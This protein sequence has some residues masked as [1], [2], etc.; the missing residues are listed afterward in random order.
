M[1]REIC[2]I[3]S[4]AAL[5]LA[6]G[7]GWLAAQATDGSITGRIVDRV[8][9]APIAAAQVTVVGTNRGTS[10]GDDGRFRILGLKPGEVLVRALRIG[11][12]AEARRAVVIPG[13]AAT[14]DFNLGTATVSLDEV[15]VTA[16]GEQERK[17]ETGNVISTIQPV[18]EVLAATTNA[19][20]LLQGRAPG[21]DVNISGGTTGGG[22]RIRI[23]GASSI[24]LSNEPLLIIDG[25][26]TNND[27][28][29]TTIGVGG[30]APSRLN[31]LNPEDIESIEVLKGPAASALFGTAAANGVIQVRTKRGRAGKT[32]W[33][34]F[35]EGGSIEKI[36]NYPANYA[37]PGVRVVGGAAT[38][39][40]TLD[41]QTRNICTPTGGI[42][43]FSPLEAASPFV[44]GYREAYGIS[45]AG[46]SENVNYYISGDYD[47]EQGVIAWNNDQRVNMRANLNAQLRNNL[48]VSVGIGYLADH[49][50]SPQN[51][52]NVLGV[53]SGG[54]LGSAFDDINTGCGATCARGYLSGQTPGQVSAINTRQDINRF[55]NSVNANYQPLRWL[56]LNG[57]AGLD[58]NN[59]LDTEVI[60]PNTVFFGS[61]PDG[62]ATSNPYNIFDYTANGNASASFDLTSTLR[63]TTSGG[64][65]FNKEVVKGTRAHGELLL[66]GTN[67]LS[68]ASARFT[69]NAANTD[70]KT[71]GFYGQEQIAWRDRLFITGAVREDNNSAFGKSFGFIKYPAV[72]GSYVVSE[73]SY[74]PRVPTLSSLRL[75]AAY[76][77]S[78]QRPNFRDAITYFQ[79]QTVTVGTTDAP[80]VLI[81]GLGDPKLK[82]ER[83][84]ET[85]LG[86][87][88][89]FFSNRVSIE[90]THYY[91]KTKDLLVAVPVAPS[92]G[93]ATSKFSNLGS[94]ENK[95]WELSLNAS[96]LNRKKVEAS[97][98][99]SGSTNTNNL[100]FLGLLPTGK[101][102]P[103]I[104]F[105]N[106]SGLSQQHRAN[107]PLGGYWARPYTYSDANL[108]GIIS[109][110]E[111]VVSD[112]S[113]YYGN[114]IPT[115]EIAFLPRIKLFNLVTVSALLEYK[116]GFKQF[117]L[118]RRF[119]CNF[120]NCQESV[121]KTRP[122]ADQAANIGQLLGT[123]AGFIENSQYT[124]LRELAFSITAPNRVARFLRA[125][126]ASITVAGRNLKTWTKYTGFDPEVNSTPAS[127]FS[128]SD[129]LTLPPNRIW[130]AR[131]SLNY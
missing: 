112:T 130:T 105:N 20:E 2:R 37:Q 64:T 126:G 99:L 110:N 74:F 25:V 101:L 67:S 127:N 83:S 41:S 92:V 108:D 88:A 52:N 26:R 129:F 119:R 102:I 19:T 34:T 111:V 121:D 53:I 104:I 39:S 125:D 114:T 57:T 68:G 59:R 91:K 72:S 29:S 28:G 43:H 12:Q 47:R 22:S 98:T 3:V 10:T 51:D 18:P 106:G 117:N 62:N 89:G 97:F 5:L 61:L 60:P 109:R 85:E 7:P 95:G 124:K 79:A 21:V 71:L 113:V 116:G 75:R 63:S 94:S 123:D 93:L 87:D 100:I 65:Q 96:V 8:T 15:T 82:P 40:C 16:T 13:Q 131:L 6:A 122:L 45:A 81:G 76:G 35:A 31:D 107:Y 120:G 49:L 86:F 23:R 14:V 50:R 1:R 55:I 46:G 17:R 24:S 44:S 30:Q 128:T 77:Q 73:E 115:R 66:G 54:L 42:V 9:Q 80:G 103:P 78:G 56:T 118:T 32:A 33:S 36:V 48:N 70:N 11:Y 90:V 58:Y 69:V 27:P 4:A 38:N 84:A